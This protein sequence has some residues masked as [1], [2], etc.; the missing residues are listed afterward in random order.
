[1]TYN[2]LVRD[3]IPEIIE[4]SGGTAHIRFL[5]EEEYLLALEHKLD[6][7]TGEYHRDKSLEEL[8]D[9]LEVVYALAQA[10][11]CSY[12]ALMA[13]YHR[14][15]EASG[16]FRNRVFLISSEQSQ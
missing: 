10:H 2:K 13:A 12:E 14:K 7:E 8:A 9:I 16:G 4:K 1:M 11:G 3:K 6:E 15:H 5:S